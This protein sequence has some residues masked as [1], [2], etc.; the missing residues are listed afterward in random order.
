MRRTI[1]LTL[2]AVLAALDLAGLAGLWQSPGPPPASAITGAVLGAVT[3]AVLRPAARGS[4]SALHVV[5]GS[6]ALSTLVG[7]PVFFTSDAPGPDRRC[8]HHRPRRPRHHA[9]D[10]RH[11]D[12]RGRTGLTPPPSSASRTARPSRR[13]QGRPWTSS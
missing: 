9:P 5:V 4:T 1:G 11:P 2:C 10:P 7:V 8:R 12:D 3:L 13:R 6:R